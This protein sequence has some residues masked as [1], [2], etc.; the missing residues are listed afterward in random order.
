V[1]LS[2]PLGRLRKPK[3]IRANR[4]L[5]AFLK[6]QDMPVTQ[7]ETPGLHTWMVWRDNLVH[8]TPLLF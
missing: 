1:A 7:I 4:K 2:P 8:F 6:T 3:R 5:V